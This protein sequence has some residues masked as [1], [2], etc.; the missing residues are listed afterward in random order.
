MADQY[1]KS[2]FIKVVTSNGTKFVSVVSNSSSWAKIDNLMIV[3]TPTGERNGVQ[4]DYYQLNKN[5]ESIA[6][7][8]SLTRAFDFEVFEI[9]EVIYGQLKIW[10]LVN[11]SNGERR[12]INLINNVTSPALCTNLNIIN[13][14]KLEYI[15]HD[16]KANQ[17]TKKEKKLPFRIASIEKIVYGEDLPIAEM[18]I[19]RKNSFL[20]LIDVLSK[21]KINFWAHVDTMIG[22]LRHHG[23]SSKSVSCDL[24]I[25]HPDT[26]K[27]RLALDKSYRFFMKDVNGLMTHER[28]PYG[29]LLILDLCHPEGPK[30]V[31]EIFYYK[32]SMTIPSYWQ[33]Q[34]DE[35]CHYWCHAGDRSSVWSKLNDGVFNYPNSWLF[36]LKEE[37]FYNRRIKIPNKAE[38]FCKIIYGP[39]ALTHQPTNPIARF[40]YDPKYEEEPISDFSPL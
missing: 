21:E 8:K 2:I 12:A 13:E 10:A 16:L 40:A 38:D 18:N 23:L 7:S 6:N 36:P 25:L 27:L 39:N 17:T 34:G 19:D 31:A 20:S 14:K 33:N 30:Q 9:E 29:T 4:F 1:S 26:E 15:Y 11:L 22:S 37:W 28:P 24:A 35:K 5:G 3:D 32:K